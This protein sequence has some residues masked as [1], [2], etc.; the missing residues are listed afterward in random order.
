MPSTELHYL[1]IEEASQLIHNRGLSSV[2]L[3]QA[4]I[5]RI[6]SLNDTL[7]AFLT[8]TPDHALQQAENADGELASGNSRGPLHGIPIALKDLCDT[9]GIR[10]TYGSLGFN[11]RVPDSDATVTERLRD[12]GTTML[13]KLTMSELAMMGPPSNGPEARNPWNTAHAPAGSSSGSGVGVAAGLFFGALG[14]DTG[15]S[16]RFPASWNGI[17]GILPSNGRVS[18]AGVMPLSWTMDNIGP[19]CRTVEDTAIML[20]AIAGPDP[21]D[22]TTSSAPVPDYRSL[23]TGDVRGL[24]IGVLRSYFD[25]HPGAVQPETQAAVDKAILDLGEMGAEVVDVEIP[26]LEYTSA[27]G[28]P[29]YIAEGYNIFQKDFYDR[30]DKFGETVKAFLLAGAL[31]TANDFIQAQRMRSRLKREV[32]ELFGQVD[33]IAGPA[34]LS[35]AVSLAEFDPMS[36]LSSVR[37]DTSV[38]FNLTGCPSISVP[39]GFSSDGL[40]IGLQLSGRYLSEPTV[41]NAAYAYQQSNPLHKQHP[42]I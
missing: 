41:L 13:G 6:D 16:I 7:H 20:K 37:G 33:L 40:P 34:T 2:E 36:L 9:K 38:V 18:R 4:H 8:P 11:D 21:R 3:T 35:T 42:P 10:T 22:P 31:F 27:A 32:E 28:A 19:M 14:S 29:I 39:C 24:K 15:G 23:L 1:T 12:A 25:R 5:D 26:N 30:P 17:S